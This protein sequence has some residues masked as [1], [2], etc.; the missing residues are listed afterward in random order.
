MSKDESEP[1]DKSFIKLVSRNHPMFSNRESTCT[2]VR[3]GKLITERIASIPDSVILCDGCNNL[4]KD[5]IVGLYMLTPTHPWGTQC[6]K[7]RKEYFSDV[8]VVNEVK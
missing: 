5:D 3:D 4:I 2:F 6:K 1:E 7:C 8:P